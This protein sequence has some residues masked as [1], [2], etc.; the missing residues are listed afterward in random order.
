MN[1]NGKL[2]VLV[3]DDEAP[4][5][6]KILRLL[7]QEPDVQV[8]GEAD[9]AEAAIA[10]I[11]KHKP[12]LVFLDVQM[13]GK[14]GFCVVEAVSA[15]AAKMLPRIIFVTAHDQYALRAFEVHAFDYLLKPFSEERFRTALNR[16]REEHAQAKDDLASQ[17][18]ALMQ[19]LQRERGYS[20]RIL[21]QEN[22]RARF[23][24]AKDI[25]WVEADG[26]YLLLHCGIKTY[27]VR[28][29][30]ES[31]KDVLDPKDFVRINRSSTVRLDAIKE[32]LPW[33]HGE[34]KVMLQDAT[35]LRWSRRF[36]KQRPELLKAK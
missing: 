20:E 13:P 31:M 32:L 18:Q 2:R 1:P 22:G 12:D 5:R 15:S 28:G 14:D 25:A 29:T 4:A 27:T 26:N 24:A 33:F 7:R 9:G 19:E 16:A 17:L 3:V 8:S 30:L 35:E 11:E 6:R 34:Y 21:V 36:V 10:A 23:V